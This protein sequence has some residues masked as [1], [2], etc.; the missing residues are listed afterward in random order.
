MATLGKMLQIL[1]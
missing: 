1:P